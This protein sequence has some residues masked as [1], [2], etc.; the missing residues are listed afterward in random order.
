MIE[1]LPAPL[2]HPAL[3]TADWGDSYAIKI[4]VPFDSARN[5]AEAVIRAFPF[6]TYPMLMVRNLVVLPFGLKGTREASLL[7]PEP[8]GFF[9]VQSEE[10]MIVV[11]G[12]DDKHLD[13]RLIIDLQITG[14]MQ[15]LC[16][17]TVVHRNNLLG[18]IYLALVL[19]FHRAIIKGALCKIVKEQTLTAAD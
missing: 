4:P 12:F 6:W 10:T 13:F 1:I 2:P 11:A 7:T 14:E 19:P 3:P 8:I 17:T 5:A 18:R 9:P 16:M 15:R